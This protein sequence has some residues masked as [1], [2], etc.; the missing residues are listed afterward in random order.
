VRSERPKRGG[1]IRQASSLATERS[2]SRSYAAGMILNIHIQCREAGDQPSMGS[3]GD[4]RPL[5]GSGFSSTRVMSTR[6]P[7]R[8]RA[9]FKWCP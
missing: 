8:V 5:P 9:G 7:A 4:A 3:V 2:S 1:S 6:R